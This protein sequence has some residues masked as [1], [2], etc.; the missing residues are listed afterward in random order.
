M[1][2]ESVS[3]PGPLALQSDALTTAPYG[4]ARFRSSYSAK[5]S[6]ADEIYGHIAQQN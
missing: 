6:N 3:N 4:L 2:P 5:E 1:W